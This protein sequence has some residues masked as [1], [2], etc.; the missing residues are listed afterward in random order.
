[1]SLMSNQSYFETFFKHIK[2]NLVILLIFRLVYL[3]IE[4]KNVLQPF[5]LTIFLWILLGF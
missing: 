2:I 1:M 3:P 5:I 4:M